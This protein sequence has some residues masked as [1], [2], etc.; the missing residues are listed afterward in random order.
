ME[1]G[2]GQEQKAMVEEKREERGEKETKEEKE[3]EEEKSDEKKGEEKNIEN[4]GE[5]KCDEMMNE[6]EEE[7]HELKKKEQEEKR[8]KETRLSLPDAACQGR[9][10]GPQEEPKPRGKGAPEEDLAPPDGG[11]GWVVTVGAFIIMNLLPM[12]P[13]CFGILFSRFLLDLRTTSTTT[14]WIFSTFCFVWNLFA[15]VCR[16]LT[17]EFGW[18]PVALYGILSTALALVISAFAP[19][20]EF[21][22]FS[23]ALLAGSGCGMVVCICFCIVPLYFDRRRGQANAIM[24]AGAGLG[25]IT[26]PPLIEF[27]QEEL[28]YKGASLIMGAVVLHGCI[29]ASLFHPISWHQKRRPEAKGDAEEPLLATRARTLPGGV[30]G[31]PSMESLGGDS[32]YKKAGNSIPVKKALPLGP[33][34]RRGSYISRNSLVSVGGSSLALSSMDLPGIGAL[35]P[36]AAEGEED[37]P[38]DTDTHCFLLKI[39]GRVWRSTLAD[40]GVL[41]SPEAVIIAVSFS[42]CVNGYITFVMM[43]PFAMEAEG[44]TL[45]DSAISI[46]ISAVCNFLLR[47]T[48]SFL[49][50]WHRFNVRHCYRAAVLL[51]SLSTFAFPL[52][53][54]LVWMKV[55]MGA[56]GA[57]VGAKMSL[58]NLVII[59][60]VGIDRLPAM[61]GS[62]GLTTA[63]GFIVI[64][65][66]IGVV[67][68]KTGS[69]LI[70]MWVL[71]AL[72][73]FS[74]CL[75]LVFPAPGGNQTANRESTEVV[76]Q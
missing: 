37:A 16:P 19:S 32:E 47:I 40:L 11:W 33:C 27:L 57:G 60:V 66:L 38:L 44:F 50:D 71:A 74:F 31:A 76:K 10:D 48:A 72:T 75:W 73:L 8:E 4:Q 12:I 59:N 46:S 30:S 36:A 51:I 43:V 5:K 49:S 52:A 2:E 18:R 56:W 28:G 17:R 7:K 9:H 1:R 53:T 69:Y 67:R 62:T 13:P 21:L 14:A 61:I 26:G 15:L 63:V 35:T 45:Q 54:E 29:G 65:P 3:E 34:R 70:S 6:E 68:D 41:R 23:F 25:Q 24:M 64:G 55:A 20:A 58:Y 39:L 22:L 42:L